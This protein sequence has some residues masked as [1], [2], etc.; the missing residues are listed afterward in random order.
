LHSE[1]VNCAPEFEDCQSIAQRTGEPLKNVI[2]QAIAL[3]W[4]GRDA[5]G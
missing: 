4:A 2:Q 3:Y 5:R 1:V